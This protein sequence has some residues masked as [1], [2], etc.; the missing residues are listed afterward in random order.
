VRRFVL[1]AWLLAACASDPGPAPIEPHLTWPVER[2]R[3][4]DPRPTL[5]IG[6]LG[7]ARPDAARVGSRPPLELGWFELSREGV[8][9]TGDADFDGPVLDALR[10][11]LVATLARSGSFASAGSVRFDPRTPAAWPASGAPDYVL[12]GTLDEFSGSQWRSF[13]V[14]PFRVGFVRDRFG[15]PTGRV[16][17]SFE[18]WSRAGLAWQGE[19]STLHKSERLDLADAVL[20]TLAL[21]DEKLAARL[22]R[23]VRAEARANRRLELR[24]LDGC[25]LGAEGVRRL[26]A[27]TSAIFERESEVELVAR[28]E[29]WSPP[30]GAADLDALL[31]AARALEP[32]P[33]GAVLALAPAEQVRDFDLATERTGLA[34]PL[35]RHALAL[36]PQHGEASVLTAAHEIGHLFG[37]VHVDDPA[38]I[39]SPT[40]DFD[41]RFFDP[42][43]RAI[44]RANRAR[45]FSA[46]GDASSQPR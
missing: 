36:C 13:L 24:V 28:P 1:A 20:E 16:S 6:A 2:E 39:M 12:I 38:S 30:A 9:R 35:G 31:A 43:N 41:A 23:S 15:A 27:E 17:A 45:D 10:A 7:D 21:N 42:A 40:A 33:G 25:G 5:G 26:I 3:P 46:A 19:V 8:E 22:D 34:V 14:T 44:L 32:P 29:P 37:A 4:D 11:D 18:L